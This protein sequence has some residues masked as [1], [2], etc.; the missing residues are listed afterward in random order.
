MRRIR[1]RADARRSIPACK[2]QVRRPGGDAD[3]T[4]P[5][6]IVAKIGVRM[7]D[8]SVLSLWSSGSVLSVASKNSV[9]SI[10]CVGSALSI[11]SIGSF[12][13]VLAVGSAVSAVAVL[14][15]LSI[16]SMMSAVSKGTVMQSAITVDERFRWYGPRRGV[17][18]RHHPPG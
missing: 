5:R 4:M 10:G 11:G 17:T 9:L 7:S 13:S 14:S 8:R 2:L 1:Q 6:I 18:Q 16:A 12:A 15:W 3:T